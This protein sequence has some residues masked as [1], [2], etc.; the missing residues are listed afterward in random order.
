MYHTALKRGTEWNGEPATHFAK[1]GNY[2]FQY[3][4]SKKDVLAAFTKADVFY[5]DA[6]WPH[7]L[8]QFNV[9]AGIECNIDAYYESL[10]VIANELNIATA[11]TAAKRMQKFAINYR[12][13]EI[14]L[15]GD[16]AYLYTKN[17]SRRLARMTATDILHYLADEYN[18]A[19]DISCGYGRTA[20]IFSQ[21]NKNWIM[22]DYNAKC[23]GY[24]KQKYG[25]EL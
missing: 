17:I 19:L 25:E 7:G 10:I 6:A 2:A 18:V 22:C 5:C 4:A 20:D 9:R 11:I 15:N 21:H 12:V 3:D 8:K 13:E 24:I 23:I 1:D 16:K 14:K